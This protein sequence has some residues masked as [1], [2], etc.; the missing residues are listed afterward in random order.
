MTAWLLDDGPFGMVSQQFDAAWQWPAD[1]LHVVHEVADGARSDKSGRRQSMLTMG[2]HAPAV[3]VHR[4]LSTSSAAQY[5][6]THLRPRAPS[7]TKNL[8]EDVAIALAA[9]ELLDVVFVTLDKAAAFVALA[10]LGPG[11]V[12]TPLDVWA[13]LHRPR[14]ITVVQRDEMT[15]RTV[16]HG[17]LPGL[18]RRF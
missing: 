2:G 5:L 7:A 4:P 18:P 10:E 1:T 9:T 15:R 14:L 16:T 17:S 8:G 11:R 6:L 3:R 12:S 13:D